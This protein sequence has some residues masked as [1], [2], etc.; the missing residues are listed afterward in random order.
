MTDKEKIGKA[1]RDMRTSHTDYTVGNEILILLY[2]NLVF[3]D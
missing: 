2:K 3:T 1:F